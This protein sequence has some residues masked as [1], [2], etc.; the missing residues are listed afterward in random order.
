MANPIE[1]YQIDAFTNQPFSGNPAAVLFSNNLPD[2]KMQQIAAEMNLSE[3]AFLSDSEAADYKL[4]WFTPTTEVDLCGHATIASLHFLYE[5]KRIINQKEISFETKSGILKCYRSADKNFMQIPYPE[6][7]VFDGCKEEIL[8]GLNIDR[9]DVCNLPFILSNNGYL[10]IAIKSLKALW[11]LKPDFLN[12][13]SLSNSKK[14]F[15]DIAL[16]TADTIE[17]NSSAHLRFFAPYHGIDEDPV[18]GSACGPMLPVLIKLGIIKNYND[19]QMLTFEQGDVLNKSGRV[20]V[21]FNSVQNNL[22]IAGE[23]VTVMKGNL[24]V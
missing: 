14:E 19:D 24:L 12:L 21:K 10:F 5:S 18:T 7:E 9:V 23:A 16:F 13:K 11:N 1:F 8:D 15:F 4:R 22:F 6:L 2:K 20:F 3:T 17:K